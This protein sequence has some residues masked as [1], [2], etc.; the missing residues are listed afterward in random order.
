MNKRIKKF[1]IFLFS[2]S[3]IITSMSTASYASSESNNLNGVDSKNK[4]TKMSQKSNKNFEYE[5]DSN[6]K[7]F[8]HMS[9]KLSDNK[10]S[11]VDDAQKYTDSINDA[12]DIKNAN[13]KVL[14]VTEDKDGSK[15][16]KCNLQSKNLTVFGSEVGV[17]TDKDNKVTFI[18]GFLADDIPNTNWK[19]EIKIKER[20]AQ[21]KSLN[22]FKKQ[23][24]NF[25]VKNKMNTTLYLYKN[26][27]TYTPAYVSQFDAT[28]PSNVNCIIIVD[29]TNGQVLLKSATNTGIASISTG[30][31]FNG[32]NVELNTNFEN[33]NY[34]LYNTLLPSKGGLKVFDANFKDDLV[35]TLV[36]NETGNFTDSKYRAS[37][38]AHYAGSKVLEYYKTKFNRD[39]YDNNGS[40]LK[41]ITNYGDK[42][43]NAFW[44]NSN[45]VALGSGDGVLTSNFASAY[46]VIGHEITHGVVSK[47]AKLVYLYQWGALN[48]S[49]ADIFGYFT[50]AYITGDAND[51]QMG[52]DC[53][54][55]DIPGDCL[56]DL[57]DPSKSYQPQP[58]HMK[59]FKWDIL[60]MLGVHTNSTIPTKAFY[61]IVNKVGSQ[62][63]EQIYYRTLTNYLGMFSDF[64][65]CKSSLVQS[66]KDLYPNEP[67]IQTI[68]KDSFTS[69]GI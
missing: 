57:K 2:L 18:N 46:D 61:N 49:F 33:G 10:I 53:L 8:R 24:S 1:G 5:K 45:V 26:N 29:A 11:T 37:V 39:G 68:I 27:E 17:H 13:I 64:K 34:Q 65:T 7:G 3:F 43:S 28:T 30:T 15:H 31:L 12:F 22:E 9:G 35:G 21:V 56:R 52:E 50:E 60:D 32:T 20:D 58:D 42:Y 44:D 69:V 48:E 38:T 19:K 4:L 14:S 25:K 66:A 47:T 23:F 40:V 62:K 41:I 16:F 55:P 63:T 54:T 67:E 36:S 6:K 51:W 59:N